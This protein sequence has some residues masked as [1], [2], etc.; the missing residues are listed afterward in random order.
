MVK[1]PNLLKTT[2]KL[3]SICTNIL[4]L[5]SWRYGSRTCLWCF[6]QAACRA[7]ELAK[8]QSIKKLVLY[9]DSKFTING[10]SKHQF[11]IE[12]TCEGDVVSPS[13]N[14][15]GYRCDMLGKELE[16]ERLEAEIWRFYHQQRRLYEA[17]PAECRAGCG[18]GEYRMHPLPFR[19]EPFMMKVL[20]FRYMFL[21][22]RVT[23]AMN[24]LTDC[25]EKELWNLKGS[26]KTNEACL[27]GADEPERGGV[28]SGHF[29]CTFYCSK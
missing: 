15:C 25:Q 4:S 20:S 3:D 24:R 16:E 13:F 21:A 22:M 12:W 27:I 10:E 9:T 23:M 17:G 5:I 7:L 29:F 11:V 1:W 18:L 28:C 14:P 19:H 6:D 8:D 2:N 26:K